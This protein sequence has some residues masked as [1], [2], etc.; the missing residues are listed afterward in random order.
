MTSEP[1]RNSE[2]SN[3]TPTEIRRDGEAAICIVWSDQQTTR[4]TAKELRDLCPCATCREK[5]RA[6]DLDSS[7]ATGPIALPVLSAAEAR[8]LTIVAMHPVG[9]Y[10]YNIAFSDGHNS[11]IYTFDRL[12][13]DNLDDA[14]TP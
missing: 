11:G 1:Q 8:P 2:S 4:W 9:T 7:S 13:R 3:A 10:A 5:Q 6:S 12:R 14:Q